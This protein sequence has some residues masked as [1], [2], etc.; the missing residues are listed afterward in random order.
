MNLNEFE[1]R[2]AD[3]DFVDLAGPVEREAIDGAA[4]RLGVS[5]PKSYV[6]FVERF[7]SGGVGS[8]S[9]LGIGEMDS[10]NV[11][12]ITQLLRGRNPERFPLTLIPIRSD[13]YGNYDCIDLATEGDEKAIIEWLHDGGP[14]QQVARSFNEWLDVVLELALE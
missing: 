11:V 5:F 4:S 12:T 7:G 13:G 3:F 9:F 6:E 14:G 10:V 8:E 1:A 2:L